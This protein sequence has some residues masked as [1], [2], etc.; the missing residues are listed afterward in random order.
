MGR[1]RPVPA[2]LSGV[3]APGIACEGPPWILGWRGAPL[4][5]PEN[6]V[7][8]FLCALE[9]GL[10]G[11]HY[12]LRSCSGGDPV[13][14][15][16]PS[17]E[18]TTDGQGLVSDQGLAEL[19]G[20]DAGGWFGKSFAGEPVPHFDDVLELGSSH[21]NA[22]LHL[23]ELHDSSLIPELVRAVGS[24]HPPLSLRVASTSRTD[25]LELRDLGLGT[26]LIA[27][28]AG[29]DD[30]AFVRDER[31]DGLGVTR[32]RGWCGEAGRESWPCERWSLGLSEAGELFEVMRAGVHG[33]STSEGRR[34][35]ALRA[36]TQLTGNGSEEHPIGA[37]ALAV[38]TSS[39]G[40][41]TGEW[42]GDWTPRLF[43]KNP[44]D[45]ACRVTVQVY[46]R[47]G[48][49]ETE[50]VPRV[51]ELAAGER[52]TLHISIRGGS[53]SPG[54]DPILA[55][56]YEWDADEGRRAGRLLLD[57]SLRRQRSAVADVITQRLEMLR[58]SPAQ[59]RASMTL[60]RQGAKLAVQVENPGDLKDV[61]AVARLDGQTRLGSRGLQIALPEG[62]DSLEAGV[63]FTCGFYGRG[64]SGSVQLRRW[65]GGL[66][67]DPGTGGSGRLFSRHWG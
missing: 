27:E 37:D 2:E 67:A 38:L 24:I 44:F 32:P 23:I 10:D 52:E 63:D 47:R 7:A 33:I 19:F 3:G 49:F 22:P 65:S 25:C 17:L 6:T 30:L 14:L 1:T 48:V 40:V 13:V 12:D 50:G 54:G 53:W 16:D 42:R 39:E 36:L 11:L 34:A 55:A 51:L 59:P 41:A 31:I 26:V 15:R 46:V 5:A 56:L 64:D 66:P 28:S 60:R 57:Q 35:L 61:Q 45:F 21:A 18:R 29:H 4:E 9:A 43:I 8:S 20:L 58:E 62:F